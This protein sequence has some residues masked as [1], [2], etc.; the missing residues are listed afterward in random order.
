MKQAE[1]RAEAA[2][3]FSLGF[4]QSVARTSFS[5]RA[6][7]ETLS[8]HLGEEEFPPVTHLRRSGEAVAQLP[9]EEVES[10]SLE[11]SKSCVDVAL[12][13]MVSGNGGV[14]LGVG[15]DDHSS[16]FQP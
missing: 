6:A 4:V 11:V 12:R 3:P 7:R 5:V 2:L 1:A 13:D 10:S 8:V 15:Q 16:L 9:R 14:L